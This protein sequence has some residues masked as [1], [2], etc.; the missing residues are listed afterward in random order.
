[1]H[2]PEKMR[3]SPTSTNLCGRPWQ[4]EK[5]LKK[6][7]KTNKKKKRAIVE[8]TLHSNFRTASRTFTPLK[9]SLLTTSFPMLPRLVRSL[10]STSTFVAVLFRPTVSIHVGASRMHGFQASHPRRNLCHPLKTPQQSSHMC[11]LTRYS[12][13]CSHFFTQRPSFFWVHTCRGISRASAPVSNS[14]VVSRR[15]IP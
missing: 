1:M 14:H 4:L 9:N 13:T 2:R 8:R 15:L 3:P 12:E 6:Q 5:N 10:L 11:G 7:K